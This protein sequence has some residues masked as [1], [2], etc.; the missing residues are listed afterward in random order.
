MHEIGIADSI[1]EASQAE[2]GR[3]AGARLIRVGI[4]IGALSGV[5]REALSFALMALTQGT[6]LSAVD[7]EIQSCSRRDRCLACGHE[8]ESEIYSDP[9]PICA[10]KETVLVGGNELDLAYVEVEEP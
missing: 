4:R 7:F 6:E 8:F 2:T 9:C 10:A 3:R 5:N 1:I